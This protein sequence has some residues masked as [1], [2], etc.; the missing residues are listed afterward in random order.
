MNRRGFLKTL[1]LA[2][3]TVV[4]PRV[5]GAAE[6]SGGGE[7]YGVLVDTTRCVGCNTCTAACAEANGL[8][9][10]KDPEAVTTPTTTQ[11]TAIGRYKTSKGEVFAKHQCMHCQVP[12]CGAACLTQAMHKTPAGPVVWRE[13]KCMG[14]RF[15][16]V[17]CPFGVPKFE[18]TS[19]NPRIRKCIMCAGRLQKG[20]QPACVEN[21]P[22]GALTFGKR[23]D[24]LR[25]ARQRIVKSPEQY[26]D[27]V[28]GE[29]EAGGTSW[30]Y[31]AGVPFDQIGLPT[32]VEETAYPNLTTSFLYSVPTVLTLAPAFMLG[33]SRA[34]R[35]DKNGKGNGNGNGGAP[36]EGN[37]EGNGG[38]SAPTSGAEP[39][40]EVRS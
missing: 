37:G 17:S 4:C 12:A 2:S 35:S 21:C 27:H 30:L 5:A 9:E 19:A 40:R 25:E 26:V 32:N 33:V 34:I 18:Y 38:A 22:E 20:Q 23:S 28:Y 3:A 39:D 11:W 36:V 1:G 10:P 24:L 8:P 29:R 15:C 31:L 6:P 13:D 16:M 14:C 7:P